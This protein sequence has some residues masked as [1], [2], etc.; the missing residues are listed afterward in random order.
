MTEDYRL[1][2]T[3]T[4]E[5]HLAGRKLLRDRLDFHLGHAKAWQK[6][7]VVVQGECPGGADRDARAWAW[8]QQLEGEPVDLERHPATDHPTQDFGG[9]PGCGPRRNRYM[10]SLGA[11]HCEAFIDVCTSIRCRRPG[12]HGSHGASGCADLA[13]A[14]KIPTTR[15]ELWKI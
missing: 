10:T 4:R 6:R 5:L 12:V 8:E 7:L 3:G 1:L 14:A 11:A 2:V 15:W 13:E 9:W